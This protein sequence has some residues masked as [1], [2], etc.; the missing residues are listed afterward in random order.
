MSQYAFFRYFV[1]P[2]ETN[3]VASL[4]SLLG[5]TADTE[6]IVKVRL[7]EDPQFQFSSS[8][9]R[10][11]D[12]LPGILQFLST[13]NK[14]LGTASG[15]TASGLHKTFDLQFWQRTEPLKLS[16][17]LLL[18]NEYNPYGILP[19]DNN[20]GSKHNVWNPLNELSSLAILSKLKDGSYKLPGVNLS[21]MGIIK[22]ALDK[23]VSPDNTAKTSKIISFE[24]PGVVY[25]PV[26]IVENVS[27][28]VSKQKTDTGFPLWAELTLNILTLESANDSMFSPL[29]SSNIEQ[30]QKLKQVFEQ[31]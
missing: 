23:G 18:H 27:A 21:N 11:E 15:Q 2:K 5:I 12:M 26:A 25:L 13:A 20:E 31:T 24:I 1:I 14:L 7:L 4:D 10:L 9:S 28:L 29:A 30:A 19:T 22:D 3:S 8:Y 17:K 16:I 6:R